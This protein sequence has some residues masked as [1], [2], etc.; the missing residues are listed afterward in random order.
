MS[1][2][3]DMEVVAAAMSDEK[4]MGHLDRIYE[5]VRNRQGSPSVIEMVFI[6]EYQARFIEARSS[7]VDMLDELVDI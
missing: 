1:A 2:V 4:L 3:A 7:F 6:R 5:L